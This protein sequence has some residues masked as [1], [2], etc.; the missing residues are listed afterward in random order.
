VGR[1]VRRLQQHV[2]PHCVAG[3]EQRNP[4]SKH[5]ASATLAGDCDA[6]VLLA[7]AVVPQWPTP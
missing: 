6:V 3:P 1:E 4:K 7:D 5:Q 2:Q